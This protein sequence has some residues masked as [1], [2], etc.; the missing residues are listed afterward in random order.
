MSRRP[1]ATSR[2]LS[3]HHEREAIRQHPPQE[4]RGEQDSTRF[5]PR[6][7]GA[8]RPG[9]QCLIPPK[10]RCSYINNSTRKSIIRQLSPREEQQRNAAPFQMVRWKTVAF[11]TEENRIQDQSCVVTVLLTIKRVCARPPWPPGAVEAATD[12]HYADGTA[13]L[14]RNPLRKMIDPWT[15]SG[16]S[17]LVRIPGFSAPEAH[18]GPLL[19]TLMSA[20][21]GAAA[22]DPAGPTQA[23]KCVKQG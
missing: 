8:G 15:L 10:I 23:R 19:T 16:F 17:S 18:E 22:F 11:W 3:V 2:R 20:G 5:Q 1:T 21:L 9:F 13:Q 4:Q 6:P 7:G 12:L 14:N